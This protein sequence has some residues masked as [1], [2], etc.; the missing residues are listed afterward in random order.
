M[1]VPDK[2]MLPPLPAN[3]KEAEEWLA[4][5]DY[6]NSGHLS[7]IEVCVWPFFNCSCVIFTNACLAFAYVW[8]LRRLLLES[9]STK[10]G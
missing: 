1:S 3:A 10:C 6:M 2:K 7:Q 8:L 5:G 9:Q 4:N